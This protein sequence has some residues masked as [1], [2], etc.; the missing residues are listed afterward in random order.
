MAVP[1][2]TTLKIGYV[3]FD[4]EYVAEED[5]IKRGFDDA[6]GGQI[7]GAKAVI[8]VR[9]PDEV[10][11]IHIREILLHEVLHACF[12]VQG[13][14]NDDGAI[15]RTQVN[16]EEFAI[17]HISPILIDVFRSNP[18]LSKYLEALR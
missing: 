4:V 9:C 18:G 12:Y 15:L 8:S 17:S 10:V 11:E 3:D 13:L 2:P 5:W 16:I 1:R 14:S 6:D 7:D